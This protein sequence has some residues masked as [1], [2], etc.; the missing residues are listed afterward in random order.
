[1]C[2]RPCP[3]GRQQ[4]PSIRFP[5]VFSPRYDD[6]APNAYDWSDQNF[7]HYLISSRLDVAAGFGIGYTKV[8]P[9]IDM[10]YTRPLLR[11][12]WRPTD[13]LSFDVHGGTEQRHFRSAGAAN[14]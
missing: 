12:A 2:C 13:K 10:S 7:F 14:L 4:R 11:V 9:G 3:D 8:D 6:S 1:M 5:P